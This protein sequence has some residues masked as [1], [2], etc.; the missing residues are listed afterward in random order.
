MHGPLEGIRVVELATTFSGPYCGLQLRQL[1]AEVI[2]VEAPQGDITRHLGTSRNPGMASVHLAVNT[3]KRSI[4]L[5][6]KHAG[7]REVLDTLLG[8][9]DV[10]LHNMRTRAT[11]RLGIDYPSLAQRFPRLVY[12]GIYG[13]GSGGPYAG[14]PAYDDIIQGVSGLATVQGMAR[15]TPGEEPAYVASTVAD[16]VAGY[17]A[18]VGIL[19]A[20]VARGV[21]GQGQEVEVPMFEAMTSFS[22]LEHQGGLTFVPSEGP[23]LYARLMSDNRRPYRTKDGYL[24]VVVYTGGH[25]VRFLERVGL[26]D[27]LTDPR[28][29]DDAG[30]ATHIDDLY[31]IVADQLKTRTTQEWLDVLEE[32]DVPAMP[33]NTLD[34]L[35]EDPHLRAVGFYHELEHDTEGTL[36]Q[37]RAPLGFSETP[38]P[39]PGRPSRLGEDGP[40]ILRGYGYSQG[41]V[42]ELVAEGVLVVP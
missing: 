37:M 24:S 28:Y 33:V 42:D 38:L 8:D 17:A 34:D 19:A 41:D 1:G 2:K 25:W 29:A 13:F 35:L 27:M 10:L 14:K 7:G 20:L 9:A 4:A 6:L 16:K 5:N 15:S 12:C 21:T 23:G 18:T 30:R 26:G 3:G 40:D 11:E 22:L 31:Q 32:L 36:R 39:E